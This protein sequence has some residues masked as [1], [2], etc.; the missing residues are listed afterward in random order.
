MKYYKLTHTY[1]YGYEYI[2][3]NL[4]LHELN[5]HCLYIQL[6]RDELPDFGGDAI[7][8]DDVAELLQNIF[9]VE[10]LRL[11][12]ES[13]LCQ[14]FPDFSCLHTL[15]LYENLSYGSDKY[16]NAI[17]QVAKHGAFK[18][19]LKVIMKFSAY[20][21][22]HSDEKEIFLKGIQKLIEGCPVEPEFPFNKGIGGKDLTGRV[23][24]RNDDAPDLPLFLFKEGD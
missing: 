6:L 12:C 23:Y 8:S 11:E 9:G 10:I 19:V 2:R 1:C 21:D 7:Y 13:D 24:V 16:K 4:T 5:I 15:D 3:T 22:F 18:E 14:K 20:H 17:K